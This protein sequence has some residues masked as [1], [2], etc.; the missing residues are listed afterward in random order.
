MPNAS[1]SR[2]NPIAKTSTPRPIRIPPER[3]RLVIRATLSSRLASLAE[4]VRV[5]R[6][7]KIISASGA[8]STRCMTG[9]REGSYR[10]TWTR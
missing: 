1:R 10:S 7:S 5:S 8:S 6:V 3:R 4:T 9:F 2:T